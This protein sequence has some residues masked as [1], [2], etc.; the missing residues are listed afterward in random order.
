LSFKY[1][2]DKESIPQICFIAENTDPLL[3]GEGRKSMRINSAIGLLLKAVQELNKN[4]E[5]FKKELSEIK[6]EKKHF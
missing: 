5:I 2:E 4:D 3:S 6:R 1:K